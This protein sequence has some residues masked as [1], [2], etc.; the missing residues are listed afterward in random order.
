VSSIDVAGRRSERDVLRA[1]IDRFDAEIAENERH[2]DELVAGVERL[3]RLLA[4][5]NAETERSLACVDEQLT[6]AVNR[7]EA[8]DRSHAAEVDRTARAREL[9]VRELDHEIEGLRAR[10]RQIDER[11]EARAVS[12]G[13]VVYRCPAP[14]AAAKGAP[15]LAVASGSAMVARF[16]VSEPEARALAAYGEVSLEIAG[17]DDPLQPRVAARV[18]GWSAIAHE[19]GM[20]V[21]RLDCEPSW[22]VLR[23]GLEDGRASARLLWLPPFW[24]DPLVQLGLLIACAGGLIVWMSPR[25]AA[26]RE[27]GE[28]RRWW[29]RAI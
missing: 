2:V 18:A 7:S 9:R 29:S 23:N 11:S 28:S 26:A 15:L 1:Q 6:A 14:A 25:L 21:V 22:D 4:A 8:A 5:M 13:T 27:A 16:R 19:P 17:H 20:A 12:A 3:E 10:L 24:L